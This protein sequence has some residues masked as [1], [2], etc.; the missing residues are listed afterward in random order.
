MNPIIYPRG[1]TSM[2]R[3]ENV[4]EAIV[5]AVEKGK[6]GACYAIADVNMQWEEM[7]SIMFGTL[8]IKRML[9]RLPLWMGF[10]VGSTMMWKERRKGKEPGLNLAYIF[11]DILA[12]E[13]YLDATQSALVLGYGSGDVA[14]AIRESTRA[15]FPDG[16]SR[17]TLRKGI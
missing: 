9:I 1:G 12:K 7:F 4:A 6:H 8:G 3:A 5:G 13:F 14:E 11:K 15:C 16:Y 17:K 2:I 10:I